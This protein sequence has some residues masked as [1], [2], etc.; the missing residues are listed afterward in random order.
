MV[1]EQWGEKQ[2]ALHAL[3]SQLRANLALWWIF[4][5]KCCITSVFDTTFGGIKTYWI[6][7]SKLFISIKDSKRDIVL[8]TT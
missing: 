2:L 4:F 5:M 8:E 6:W 1:E 7:V 3:Q